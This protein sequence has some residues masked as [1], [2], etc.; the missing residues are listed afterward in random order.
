M[1]VNGQYVEVDCKKVKEYFDKG[2]YIYGG[3]EDFLV[4]C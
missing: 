1:Y 3:L 2:V 4:I